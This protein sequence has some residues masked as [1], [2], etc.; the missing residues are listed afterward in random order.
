MEAGV[1][2]GVGVEM[3]VGVG[4]VYTLIQA[5]AAWCQH[6][7]LQERNLDQQVI[8]LK[9]TSTSCLSLLPQ[10]PPKGVWQAGLQACKLS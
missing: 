6:T 9:L 7:V 8:D 10:L 4:M 5:T 2:L 3:G 1:E